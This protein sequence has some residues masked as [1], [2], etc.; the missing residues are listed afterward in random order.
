MKISK[1]SYYGLR[2][3]L[4]LA[5]AEKALSIHVLAEIEHLPETYLEKILQ[6]LRKANLVTAQKGVSGGYALSRPAEEINVWEILREL[7]PPMK[8]FGTVQKGILPC[9]QVSHCQT[10]EVWRVLEKQIE[11]TLANISIEQ[12]LS[13]NENAKAQITNSKSN[14]KS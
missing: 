13:H 2:A 8:T 14:P 1:K 7:D 6:S 12:L 3:V 5:Q 9:F 4:A 11:M 10:N